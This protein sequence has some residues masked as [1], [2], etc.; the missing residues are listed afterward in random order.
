MYFKKD[1][2]QRYIYIYILILFFS[3]IS[4][5]QTHN[6]FSRSIHVMCTYIRF[7]NGGMYVVLLMI[8]ISSRLILFKMKSLQ[9]LI[10]QDEIHIVKLDLANCDVTWLFFL[11]NLESLDPVHKTFLFLSWEALSFSLSHRVP[12]IPT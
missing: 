8:C 1:T 3:M 5:F 2:M 12:T 11:V 7:K 6:T 4:L 10:W 9:L